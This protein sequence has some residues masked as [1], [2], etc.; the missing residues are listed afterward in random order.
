MEEE[1]QAFFFFNFLFEVK[2]TSGFNM[3][4][5][6]WATGNF[7]YEVWNVR[8]HFS[9]LKNGAVLV[10]KKKKIEKLPKLIEAERTNC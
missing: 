7:R 3:C 10:K 4:I 5:M 2:W 9:Y 8:G 6:R 1:K